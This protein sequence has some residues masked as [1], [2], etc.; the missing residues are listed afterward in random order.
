[1]PTEDIKPPSRRSLLTAA[2]AAVLVAGIVVGYGLMT[3]AQSKQESVQW[4]DTPAI[5][6]AALAQL[7]PRKPHQALTLPGNVQPFNRATIFA[8]VNGY[9][10]SW[11]HDIGSS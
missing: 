3:R 5:P 9:V 10:K 2:T 4:T 6:T 8:R 7:I 1:M 11:D